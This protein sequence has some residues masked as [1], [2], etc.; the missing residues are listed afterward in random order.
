MSDVRFEEEEFSTKF[1]AGTLRRMLGQLKP[2][3]KWV[4]LFMLLIGAVSVLDAYFT[5]LGKQIIDDGIVPGD[6]SVLTRLLMTY[7]VIVGIEA[8]LVFSFICITGILGHRVQYDMRKALFNHLQDLSFSYFDRTPV[9]WIMSRVTSDT[10]RIAEMMTW[11][12]LDVTWSI[13]NISSALFF[14]LMINLPLALIVFTAIPILIGVAIWFKQKI[15]VEYREV[16]KLNSKITGAYNE[17]IQGVRVV[18]ALARE[19]ENL[20]EFGVLTS[21]MYRSSY[22]AAWL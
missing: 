4:A 15:L 8:V 14:M 17:N 11:G 7:G 9:G 6:K 13:V 21:G 20:D 19:R 10:E 1:T 18:K 16:R 5:Y 2:H 22:R 12:L 3:W